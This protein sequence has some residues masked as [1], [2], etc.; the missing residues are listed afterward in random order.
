MIYQACLQHDGWVGFPDF[1]VRVD[2]PHSALGPF[3]YEVHD[4][5]LARDSRPGYVFQLLFYD[6]ELTRI[7]GVRPR[8][9]HLVLG[10]GER[11][12]YR[13]EEF[14]AYGERVRRRYVER[15]AELAAGTGAP[16]TYPYK[17]EHCQFCPWWKRCADRRRADDHVSLV[18]T[19]H[20]TQAIKLEAA[21][22]AHGRRARPA[23][24][25]HAGRQAL[26]RDA[27]PGCGCRPACSSRA[28][29]CATPSHV[30]LEPEHGHGL[31]RLPR[32]SDGDLF[33]DFE[34]D[35]WWGDEGLEYLFGT[36]F[37]E[38]GAWR[39]DAR[40]ATT[41]A[42]EKAT[43]EAWIDWV[44]ARLERHPD[45]HVFHYNAYEPT[46]VKRLAARH[47]TREAEVDELLRRQRLRRPLR[48]RAPGAAHRRRVLRAQGPR[49]RARLRAHGRPRLAA[50]MVGVPRDRRPDAARRDRR[51]QR[52]G[53]PLDA[54]AAA[55]AARAPRRTPSAQ[56][57]I[58]LDE[59]APQ[60]AR[61][62]ERPHAA[63]PR[64]ARGAAR[65]AD[66]RPARQR[67]G[68]RRRPARAPAAVRPAG[69]PPPRGQAG[70]VGV[71]RA[72]RA[73]RRAAPRRGLRGDRRPDARSPARGREDVG[74]LLRLDAHATPSRTSSSARAAPATRTAGRPRSSTLD[75]A[76]RVVRVKR[77]KTAGEDPPT[78]LIP[79]GP[80]DCTKQEEALFAIAERV[81]ASGLGPGGGFDAALDL[82]TRRRAAARA[83]RARAR[84]RAARPRGPRRA[85][86]RSAGL[87]ARH[88]GPARHRQDVHRRPARRRPHAP[89]T[90]RRRRLDLPQGDHQH[91]AGDR[92][93]GRRGAV[94]LRRLEEARRRPGHAL[95][96]RP[97]LS[98]T[99]PPGPDDGGPPQCVGATAW[100]WAHPD[101]RAAV[102]VLFVDEA[103]QMS[104]ADAMACAHG[105]PQRR[106]ARRPA[107][108]RARQP[109]HPRA[110]LRRIGARPPARR[111][112]H[113]R[114]RPRRLPRPQLAACTRTSAAS[115]RTRCTTASSSP[116]STARPSASSPPA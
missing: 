6:R 67:A 39:Y 24:G 44:M 45:L 78:S 29:A 104:L 34:G 75:E 31:H 116:S 101:Q 19:V 87:G 58:V 88:P 82:L 100:H 73:H 72:H 7:Q 43:F 94:R 3:S 10:D 96:E 79:G 84:R 22:V 9:M 80:Y 30:L 17:V 18:A 69:L 53:L 28:A 5:K 26:A 111:A 95:H 38:D 76:A 98:G 16:V 33:F 83:R 14:A 113:R 35:P 114:P 56:F 74:A 90:H 70:V 65:A 63:L 105:A 8:W 54:V 115:S 32:P 110:R 112:R 86:P 27:A 11:H 2:E 107:A 46:A 89:R 85:G 52:G 77:A 4:A 1:L 48:H 109:G 103:G 62:P 59:L 92:R 41:R 12:S 64:P 66:R 51:L 50:R 97:L 40:W 21:G 60:A 20:R 42:E 55:L 57:G 61:A 91:A 25:G 102:D 108:A 93:G 23:S 99:T 106:A 71:L 68:R 15:R 13:P 81:V 49:A 36:V 47:A 37:L